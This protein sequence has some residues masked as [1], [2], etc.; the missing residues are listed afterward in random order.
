MWC[1]CDFCSQAS[2]DSVT[3]VCSAKQVNVK[4]PTAQPA[5]VATSQ[6]SV[7]VK[8]SVGTG[9]MS[10][11]CCRDTFFIRCSVFVCRRFLL[12]DATAADAQSAFRRPESHT[13]SFFS[14]PPPS[15]SRRVEQNVS[16]QPSQ[17]QFKEQQG[18]KVIY[19][20]LQLKS[21][22][23]TVCL[24]LGSNDRPAF[25]TRTLCICH[26]PVVL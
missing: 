3:A 6:G 17:T 5:A 8:V 1:W 11:T 24:Q 4:A 18:L 26:N 7:L 2:S 10:T 19:Q 21:G 13:G 14:R 12:R 16:T 25:L 20:I 23:A 9:R 15:F 22:P